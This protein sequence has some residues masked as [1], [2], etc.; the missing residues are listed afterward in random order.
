MDG[1]SAE[2]EDTQVRRRTRRFPADMDV[3]TT[4]FRERRTRARPDIHPDLVHRC[5][6]PNHGAQAVREGANGHGRVADSRALRHDRR[7]SRSLLNWA[8]RRFGA[9]YPRL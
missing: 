1:P 5:N 9:R 2:Y 4:P 8:F 6:A 3:W 7:V